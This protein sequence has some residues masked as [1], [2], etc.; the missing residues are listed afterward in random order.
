MNDETIINR[1]IM[2]SA[3]LQAKQLRMQYI[4]LFK[5][6]KTQ[7]KDKKNYLQELKISGP[8]VI[9]F[10][11]NNEYIEDYKLPIEISKYLSKEPF[12]D[13]NGNQEYDLAETFIDC[14]DALTICEDD[15]E[16]EDSYGN[17]K[18]DEGEAYY[19]SNLNNQYDFAEE[20]DDI[21]GNGIYD[22][23]PKN[24]ISILLNYE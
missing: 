18:Y 9:F 21:N 12:K 20:Y 6:S 14:D 8:P 3:Y 10:S 17:G 13:L 7:L 16:W 11:D 24:D 5:W 23:Q 4:K 22:A 1:E 19:D 2:K 15:C